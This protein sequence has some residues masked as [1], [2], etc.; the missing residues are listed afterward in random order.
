MTRRAACSGGFDRPAEPERIAESQASAARASCAGAD[1]V[2]APSE[3]ESGGPF[4]RGSATSVW[5][6]EVDNQSSFSRA[7][8]SLSAHKGQKKTPKA[9][10]RRTFNPGLERK[11]ER[12]LNP[13]LL[14]E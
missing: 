7:R 11:E 14:L 9:R 1:R 12:K 5:R 6:R 8:E 3:C 13:V 2:L 4:R 10:T